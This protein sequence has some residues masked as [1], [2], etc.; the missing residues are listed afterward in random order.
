M[1][2]YSKWG[3]YQPRILDL[4]ITNQPGIVK[5][6]NVIPGLFDHEIVAA[7]CNL[8]PMQAQKK[9]KTVQLYSEA[10]WDDIRQ[11]AVEF[12]DLFLT[13][14]MNEPSSEE[15]KSKSFKSFLSHI[16]KSIPSKRLSSKENV[17]WLTHETR[18]LCRKK[19][20][21]IAKA[22]RSHSN[23]LWSKYK[24][25]KGEWTKQVQKVLWSTFPK[26]SAAPSQKMAKRHSENM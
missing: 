26:L 16:L 22:K 19:S 17:P 21:C 23:S 3:D 24:M 6:H 2:A 10:D 25:L 11:R 8:Q 18:K 13:K 9:P 15:D 14:A 1:T 4:F 12:K 5:S 20:A 7:D